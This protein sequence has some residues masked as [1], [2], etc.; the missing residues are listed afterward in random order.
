[1]QVYANRSDIPGGST[2]GSIATAK[3]SVPSVDIGLAQLAMHASVETAGA[4]DL[5]ALVRA[6]T[7]YYGKTLQRTG[8]LIAF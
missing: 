8:D 5:D 3:V 7:V 1:M 4:E 6:M 2:L